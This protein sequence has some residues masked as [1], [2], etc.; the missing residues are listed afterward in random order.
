MVISL[1]LIRL[2]NIQITKVSPHLEPAEEHYQEKILEAEVLCNDGYIGGID[3]WR[4]QV[5]N[6]L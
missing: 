2:S 6:I 1:R 4:S 3:A 5:R